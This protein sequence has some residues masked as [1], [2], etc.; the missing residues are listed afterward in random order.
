MVCFTCEVALAV[1]RIRA[2]YLFFQA[3]G[4]QVYLNNTQAYGT[5]R[6]ARPGLI[7]GCVELGDRSQTTQPFMVALGGGLC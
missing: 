6:P 2:A 3:V 1:P 4:Y 5:L 7:L